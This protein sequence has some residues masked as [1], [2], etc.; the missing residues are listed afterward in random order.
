MP[1]QSWWTE[2]KTSAGQWT[3]EDWNWMDYEPQL[4]VKS[5]KP[6][7]TEEKKLPLGNNSVEHPGC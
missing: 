4:T 6:N 5:M 2:L 1:L 7:L 3:L